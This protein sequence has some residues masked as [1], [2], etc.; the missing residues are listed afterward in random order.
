VGWAKR[1]VQSPASK[2]ADA[3]NPK[4]EKHVK[5]GAPATPSVAQS[6]TMKKHSKIAALHIYFPESAV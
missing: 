4:S 6:R 1:S 5:R 3:S 2:Y